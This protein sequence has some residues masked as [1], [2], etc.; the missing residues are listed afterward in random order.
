MASTSDQRGEAFPPG[1]V[2]LTGYQESIAS[3]RIVL[4]P[5][6]SS[7]PNEPLNW[8]TWRKVT[9]M[10]LI[11]GMTLA[12]FTSLMVQTVFWQQMKV[13]MGVSTVNLNNAQS[14]NLAGVALGCLFFIPL[15]VKYG[16][17]PSYLL[18]IAVLAGSMWWA[19]KMKTNAELI[20]I[21]VISG[22]SGAINET[23]VQM[24]IADLFF[25]HQRGAANAVYF[26]AVMMGSF[27]TPLAAGSQA[28]TQ[29]WRW[30]YTT[31]SICLTILFVLF[32][33][34]YEE[35]KYIPVYVGAPNT[36]AT[37][38]S[39]DDGDLKNT[40]G[41]GSEEI[42]SPDAIAKLDSVPSLY[43]TTYTPHTYRQR[44]RLWT[45]TDESLGRL[46]VLPLQVI[47]LPHVLYTS[48]QFAAVIAWLVLVVAMIS[49]IFSM[50]PYSFTTAGVGYMT[51]GP[52]VGN[53]F[54]TLYGGPLSDWVVVRLAR[55]NRDIFEPEMRLHLL[56]VPVVTMAGGLI[57]F[58]VTA[59]RGMHWIFPSIGGAFYAFGMGSI[60]EIAF[61]VLLDSYR[62]LVA[63]SFIVVAFFRN[64]ISMA[65]PFAM[66]PW[67]LSMGLSNMFIT[68]GCL[69]LFIGLFYVP[70]LIWGKEIRIKLAP[71][72]EKLVAKK[73]LIG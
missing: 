46:F 51:L 65:V 7:D 34:A 30:S 63:E 4:S 13:D 21:A 67:W 41:G 37:T 47:M 27:L 70:L 52:F 43:V 15:T 19:S 20:V 3:A 38:R 11:F 29:G 12:V 5:Q 62:D 17:R 6:P 16:R 31:L 61:T 64:A 56:C 1:T 50:P 54:G 26:G 24:T 55:R 39:L 72:Y 40:C 69:S 33:F 10:T 25:V 60:G 57:M 58:G 59:D 32:L 49:V 53:V 28:A 35:T 68:I 66:V 73:R 14:A 8:P 42:K 22:L 48:L 9:N 45:P 18:S 23:A 71:R 36:N 2:T 44:M